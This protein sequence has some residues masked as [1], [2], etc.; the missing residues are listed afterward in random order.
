MVKNMPISRL[1]LFFVMGFTTL[2]TGASDAASRDLRAAKACAAST[3]SWFEATF[4]I[5][6]PWVLSSDECGFERAQSEHYF[7]IDSSYQEALTDQQFRNLVAL[8]LNGVRSDL[9]DLTSVDGGKLGSSAGLDPVILP[10]A[11]G[12]QTVSSE[13]K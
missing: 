1:I 13:R 8:R 10:T 11:Q 5:Y 2:Q 6:L 3:V 9:N 4:G 12:F 7:E